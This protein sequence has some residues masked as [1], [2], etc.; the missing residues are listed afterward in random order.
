[1]TRSAAASK[2]IRRSGRVKGLNTMCSRPTSTVMTW[3]NVRPAG[4]PFDAQIGPPIEMSTFS[5]RTVFHSPRPPAVAMA[6][7]S[8][9]SVMD[10]TP[11]VVCTSTKV[12]R[13]SWVSHAA[14]DVRRPGAGFPGGEVA[15]SLSEHRH[16]SGRPASRVGVATRIEYPQAVYLVCGHDDAKRRPASRSLSSLRVPVVAS[17]SPSDSA[18]DVLSAARATDS[19]L[20][21]QSPLTAWPAAA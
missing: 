15:P 6:R 13:S 19:P 4:Q 12:D 20:D 3:S 5:P 14:L 7:S 18:A 11:P 17:Q 16:G 1:M 8:S 21:P 2:T 10:H 9:S